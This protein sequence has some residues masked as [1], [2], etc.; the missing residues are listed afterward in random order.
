MVKKNL[1]FIAVLIILSVLLSSCNLENKQAVETAPA[2]TMAGDGSPIEATINYLTSDECGGRLVGTIGNKKAQEYFAKK[3]QEYSV[4]PFQGSYYHPYSQEVISLDE[5][6][7]ELKFQDSEGNSR[8][9]EYGK[10]YIDKMLSRCKIELPLSIGNDIRENCILITKDITDASIKNDKVKAVLVVNERFSKNSVSPVQ[11]HDKCI[12]SITPEVYEQLKGIP[13]MYLFV[14]YTINE[15]TENNVAGI[16]EGHNS[17]KAVLITAHIDHVGSIGNT[18]WRGAIDNS[19]GVAVMAD[20]ASRLAQYAK[21]NELGCD[22]IFCAA[23]GEET[24]LSG[25]RAFAE[26]TGGKY[27]EIININLDC[28]GEKGKEVIY[29]DG[30]TESPESKQL[31]EAL[32]GYLEQSGLKSEVTEDKFVSDH[33]SFSKSVNV[34]TGPDSYV[35]HSTEDTA[36]KLDAVF[37][38]KISAALSKFVI[39]YAS[40][41]L[42]ETE[43]H[44]S[45][46]NNMIN[47]DNLDF[48]QYKFIEADGKLVYVHNGNFTGSLEEANKLF[49][50]ELSFIPSE[51]NGMPLE[52]ININAFRSNYMDT[53]PADGH[54]PGKIY[55]DKNTISQFN[56][57]Y[58]RYYSKLNHTTLYIDKYL[59]SSDLDMDFYKKEVEARISNAQTIDINNRRYYIITPE[60]ENEL[61]TLA[62]VEKSAE[63]IYCFKITETGLEDSL[64]EKSRISAFIDDNR[65]EDFIDNA[66]NWLNQ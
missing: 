7:L 33:Q 32:S 47:T 21:T 20:M 42:K 11:V 46:T 24:V 61:Y 27:I 44:I 29:I 39:E 64:K 10:D 9:L 12:F 8:R 3:L 36:D 13:E 52:E 14:D 53:P 23:N 6:A 35:I 65:I 38:E 55:N 18:I 57:M 4:K 19:S 17:D 2:G 37:M 54:E 58:I 22:I 62:Y 56:N 43:K 34:N 28:L 1:K 31:A 59:T 63:H 41:E 48:G 5:R 25:S 49:E 50:S 30:K 40:G 15:I 60:T 51:F 45:K 16:L 66:I 26:Q